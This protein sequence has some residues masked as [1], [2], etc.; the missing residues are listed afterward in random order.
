V[1]YTL[2]LLMLLLSATSFGDPAIPDTP[3]G[4]IFAAWIDAYNSGDPHQLLAFKEASKDEWEIQDI[5]D[6]RQAT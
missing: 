4:K 5:L 1:K 6:W 2:T 3:L